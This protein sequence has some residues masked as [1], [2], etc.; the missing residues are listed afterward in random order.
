M[1]KP[2]V[3]LPPAPSNPVGK[4]GHQN[5]LVARL[6]IWFGSTDLESSPGFR[7]ENPMQPEAA[8]S[9]DPP[10]P[11]PPTPR[12]VPPAWTARRG[13]GAERWKNPIHREDAT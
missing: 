7:E 2:A 5:R 9:F 10:A 13:D 8:S 6:T 3:K 1:N 12:P 11:P 4:P